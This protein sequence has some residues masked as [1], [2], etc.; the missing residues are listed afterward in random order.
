MFEIPEYVTLARQMNVAIRGKTVQG[1]VLGNSPHKFVWYNVKQDEFASTIKGKIVGPAYSKGRWLFI[2]LNPVHVLVF[3][4]CGGKI[5]YHGSAGGIP[6]KY[7]LLVTF[8]DGTALSATTRMWGAMELYRRGEEVKRQ[9]IGDM[10]VTPVDEGF[11]FE[12]FSKL[13]EECCGSERRSIK[14]F[15]TQ[16]QL[17]PG[18][19]NSIAQDIMFNAGLHPKRSVGE[20]DKAQKRRLYDSIIETVDAAIKLGGR[21]DEYDL[22]GEKGG[23]TRILDKE[24]LKLGCIKCGSSIE[25]IQYL[26]GA[27]YFC[28]KCQAL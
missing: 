28:P 25:K 13:A 17:I 19:G 5:L 9:Y 1:G 11:T 14:G 26:G 21:N 22:F 12:Y 7:H 24:A 8:E 23:Y 4:E 20:L 16:D 2:P 15:L 10:R 18:L 3:G 27:S 6:K